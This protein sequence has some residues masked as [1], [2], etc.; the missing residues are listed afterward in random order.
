[1]IKDNIIS[2]GYG[3]ILVGYSMNMIKLSEIKPPVN[4]GDWLE[5]AK[6]KDKGIEV[7][8]IVRLKVELS[9]LYKFSDVEN[10]L[11]KHIIIDDYTL[12]FTN[13]NQESIEIVKQ[14]MTKAL[15]YDLM[16]LAC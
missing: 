16:C 14:A 13:Y 4:V 3:D 8:K 10:N 11:I 2:F 5:I 6:L 9:D 15:H 1:M 7:T 12:D